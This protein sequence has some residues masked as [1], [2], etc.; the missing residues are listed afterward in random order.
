VDLSQVFITENSKA[1]DTYPGQIVRQCFL[2]SC[3]S[4]RNL[5]RF[6]E[7]PCFRRW[8]IL[9]EGYVS[10]Q[11]PLDASNVQTYVRSIVM[12]RR[13]SNH[14]RSM[15]Q[16]FLLRMSGRFI[17]ERDQ[18]QDGDQPAPGKPKPGKSKTEKPGREVDKGAQRVKRPKKR[19]GMPSPPNKRGRSG[20]VLTLR[21]LCWPLFFLL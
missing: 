10:C 20:L 9:G 17:S 2:F 14:T 3:S 7:F 1:G 21:G 18:K 12:L 13:T 19:I 6:P 16:Q 11:R 15:D 8:S 5:T 4:S